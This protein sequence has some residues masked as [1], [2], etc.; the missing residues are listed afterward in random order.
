MTT[1]WMIG[2]PEEIVFTHNLWEVSTSGAVV[3]ARRL[4]VGEEVLNEDGEPVTGWIAQAARQA[5]S[6]EL[7]RLPRCRCGRPLPRGQMIRW[8]HE[9]F[10][11][12]ESALWSPWEEEI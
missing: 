6:G 1:V 4:E 12:E 7:V 9:C 2:R 8:C 10:L 5:A 3:G 11:E